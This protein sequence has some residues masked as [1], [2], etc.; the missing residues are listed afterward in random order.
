MK[1]LKKIVF[2]AAAICVCLAACSGKKST[3][4]AE[5][6]EAAVQSA[7][8]ALQ[9]LDLETFNALTD[10]YVSTERNW[11]GIPVRRRYRVFSELQQPGILEGAKEKANRAFAEK[12]V[13]NLTW[14]I[15]GAETEGE[16]SV[17]SVRITNTDMSDVMGR[18]TVHVLEKM[19]DGKG[20]GLKELFEEI[21]EADYDRGGVLPYLD[22]AEG[23]VTTD[24]AVTVC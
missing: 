11:L 17:I 22:E 3:G 15:T 1:G 10:N 23:S 9:T 12:I 18:Y 16:R 19:T 20:T 6:P 21:A 2:M 7:M 5:T 13:K 4:Y 24:V 14:E 8:E